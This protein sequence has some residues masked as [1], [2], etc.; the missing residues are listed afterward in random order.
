MEAFFTDLL[1]I[2]FLILLNGLFAM[3][4]IALVS[5]RRVRLQKRVE[6]GRLGAKAALD[7]HQNS[8]RFLSTIQVGITSIGI[9]SGAIGE[10]ALSDPLSSWLVQISFMAPYAKAMS[11]AI[12]VIILTY[13]S[14]VIGELVPKRLAL[15]APEAIA[16]VMARPMNALSR[17]FYPLV[18]LFSLSSEVLLGLF[19]A[20][21]KNEPPISDNEIRLLMVQGAEA[22]IFH[23]SEQEI[24]SNVLRLDLQ[25]VVEIMTPRHEM[26][27]IDL[28]DEPEEIRKRLETSD[29]ARLV[30]CRGG[31]EQVVGIM[32]AKDLLKKIVDGHAPDASD[33]EA[34]VQVP[35]YVPETV[36][37]IRLMENFRDANTQFALIVDEYGV[38]QGIVTSS[39]VMAA[40]V[41]DLSAIKADAE[42]D[43]IRRENGSWLVDGDVTIEKLSGVLALDD[44]LPGSG[45]NRF[46][47]VGGFLMHALGK[48]P[49]P[50]DYIDAH[51]W[52]FEVMD[53]EKNRVDKVL[54]S[55]N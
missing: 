25:P 1:L 49:A 13:L 18:S 52:R 48:I 32:Q 11:T 17:I 45:E 27:V 55:K 28:E 5:S 26:A 6:E 46:Y 41:G 47:T 9:L 29:Y 33:I 16:S 24:V 42:K 20:R 37:T 12:T 7:L 38:V 31:M 22:G 36:S 39:D 4:E 15:L 34:I 23:E 14:V 53:M 21:V 3:A 8:T 2:L 54:I 35:L 19:R 43:M 51:G 50:A 30:V 10:K 40:I 44:E